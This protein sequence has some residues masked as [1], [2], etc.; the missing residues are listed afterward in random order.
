MIWIVLAALGIPLWVVAGALVA[1]LWCRREFKRGPETFRA[2]TRIVTGEV[3]GIKES[4]SRRLYARW[5]HDVVVVHRGLALV[6]RNELG[7]ARA[8]GPLTMG[9]PA[10]IRGLGAHPVVLT[11][12]LDSGAAVQLAAAADHRGT[13]VG[14]FTA[15]LFVDGDEDAGQT[16]TG[17]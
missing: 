1:A 5:V 12:I 8:T 16:V 14:P 13:M 2:R 10:E 6:R 4:W 17:P 15:A 3:A 11:L 9:D 7:V